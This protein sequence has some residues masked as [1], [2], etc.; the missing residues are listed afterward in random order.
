MYMYTYIYIYTYYRS[1]LYDDNDDDHYTSSND[2]SSNQHTTNNSNNNHNIEYVDIVLYGIVQR[3]IGHPA[4]PARPMCI[5][6]SSMQQYYIY[7][8]MCICTHMI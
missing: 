3:S 2:N 5:V 1:S 6:Y 4:L 8:Y 7:I